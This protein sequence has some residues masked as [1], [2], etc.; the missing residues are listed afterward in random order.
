MSAGRMSCDELRLE[1][2]AYA[3]GVAEDPERGEIA[4]HLERRCPECGA[5]VRSAIATVAVLCGAVKP[6]E[7]PKYLRDRVIGMVSRQ[8]ARTR[9]AMW[10]PWAVAAALAVVLASVAIPGRLMKP[11]AET[12]AEARFGEVLSIL[13]DPLTK[14][15][16]FGD[17][18]ARGRFFVSPARGIFF[19]AAHMPK[20]GAGRTFQMWIIPA[21][22]KPVPAGIFKP[23]DD[24]TALCVRSGPVQSA[25]AMAISVEPDGG[26]PQPT[27]TPIIISKI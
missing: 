5:G 12:A 13:N 2:G 11:A 19:I 21:N 22:G 10:F 15:A 25:A 20:P 9:F 23:L 1:Y 18:A 7:P 24:S 6:A 27:T 8:P 3:L 26:S 14:D 17:P 16:A 4:E